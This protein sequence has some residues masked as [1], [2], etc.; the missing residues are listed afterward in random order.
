MNSRT[1]LPAPPAEIYINLE[2]QSAA[3]VPILDSDTEDSYYEMQEAA[4]Q[5]LITARYANSRKPLGLFFADH[6]S[7]QDE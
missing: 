2:L 3:E 4:E 5:E 6:R 1:E 7:N